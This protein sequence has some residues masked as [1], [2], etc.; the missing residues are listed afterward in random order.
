MKLIHF[1][2]KHSRKSIIFSLIAG[3]V[4]GACNA[5]LLAVINAELRSGR[6]TGMTVLV[7]A[8]VALCVT[9]PV[10]RFVSELVL[11]RLGQDALYALRLDL[12]RQLLGAPLFRLEQYGAARLLSVL[13]EDVPNITGTILVLPIM[14]VNAAV[15]LGCLVYMGYLYWGLLLIVLGFMVIGIISYQLPVLHAQKAFRR[16]RKDSNALMSHFRALTYGTKELKIHGRRRRAFLN[17]VLSQTAA[18]FRSNNLSGMTI[19]TAAASWGQTLVFVVVGLIVIVLPAIHPVDIKTLSGYT[20]ALLYLMT[21][22]QMIM[23]MLPNIAR[24]NVALSNVKEL[25]LE[26]TA[27]KENEGAE[28]KLS[29]N[30]QPFLELDSIMHRY[31][32]DGESSDFILGPVQLV[33]QPGALVFIAG[34]NGSGKTTLA[35]LLTGL[36]V[37]ESGEIRCDGLTINDENRE[38]YRQL[39]SVVFSDFFLFESL[40]GLS[41]PNLDAAANEYLRELKLSHKVQIREGRLSTIDL[42][43]GE[44]KR[45]ALLTAFLEERPIYLFDEWAADQDPYFKEIFYLRILPDLKARNKTVFVISHDDRYYYLADRLIKLDAGQVVSDTAPDAVPDIRVRTTAAVALG[46]STSAVSAN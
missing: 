18:S 31:Q 20:L 10:S 15:V 39:F 21:P 26:L 19:Y 25:G 3:I 11:N 24:A 14:S 12:T 41:S 43:Q 40:L 36:Y 7:W 32:R 38:Q 46:L 9:L 29:T 16:A 1:F 22:L 45:L 44:R 30:L 17:E 8:F 4:S 6:G 5:A 37:P 34:G 2:L 33:F 42:S 23:N 28:D 35:K 27:G 13:T